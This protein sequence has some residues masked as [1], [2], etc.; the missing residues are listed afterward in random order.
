MRKDS[1]WILSLSELE[2]HVSNCHVTLFLGNFSMSM[3]SASTIMITSVG[4]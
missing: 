3:L 4:S 1:I 2:L